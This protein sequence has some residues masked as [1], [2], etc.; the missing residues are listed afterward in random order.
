MYNTF[1]EDKLKFMIYS[2][3]T[4]LLIAFGACS[5]DDDNIETGEPAGNHVVLVQPERNKLLKNPMTGWVIYTGLGDGLSDKF[6]EE[7][8][9]FNSP[10]G[11]VKVSDYATTLFIRGAWSDFN[12]EEGKYVWDEDVNTKPAQ[13]FKWL[14]EGAKERNLKLAFSFIVDSRDKHYNFTPNYVKDAPGIEGYETVTGSVTVWS[15]YPDNAVFQ[16]Y[17]KKFVEAVA[18]KYD[19]PHLVQFISGTGLGKW[20]ESHSL[21]Y[22]TE[23]NEPKERVFDWVT[24][25][26]ANAFK[27][28]PIVI[29]YHRCMLSRTDWVD[30]GSAE[31]AQSLK[32]LN[33]AVD[34]GY[35]LRHDA[36]GMKSYYKNWERNY[37]RGKK[38]KRPILMEGGWVKNS[39]GS[40]IT[41][42]GYATYADVRKGE[43]NDAKG[44]LVNMMDFRYSKD[45]VNGETYS[46]FNDA[47]PLVEEFIAEGGYRLYPDR[48][49][50][51]QN[52]SNGSTITIT[53]RWCNL[54]WGY[55][56]TNIPQWKDRYKIAFALLDKN[57]L[58]PQ[59]VYVNQEPE[60]SDCLQS[61]PRNYRLTQ[62]I[63][64]V[65]SGDYIWAVGIVDTSN[66]NEI[67]IQISAREDITSE[68]WLTLCDVTVQ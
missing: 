68:G 55:C 17:Y 48:L 14:V 54:G 20:G 31:I 65:A 37:A 40:S 10:K 28:V 67:G 49:T 3:I 12:P 6:W 15:P 42:D 18:Q 32:L 61:R 16:E 26:Y 35:S 58:L 24:D 19:D 64:N 8:D 59:H 29:N 33:R 13:R 27:K 56:P 63:S 41:G 50:L 43:Y 53:H 60:L 25:V 34:K 2:L 46:W 22:S 5:D 47:F 45:I 38:Y 23:N 30:D 4:A 57:T 9:N 36:F 62:N 1:K 39:H 66:N 51:P 11:K 21:R 44:A 7:Y 52:I